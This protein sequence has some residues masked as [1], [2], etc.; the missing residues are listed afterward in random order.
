MAYMVATDHR[1]YDMQRA[2][3]ICYGIF[4]KFFV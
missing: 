4:H 2:H 1:L 3:M